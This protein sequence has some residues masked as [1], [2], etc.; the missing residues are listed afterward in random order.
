MEE[1]LKISRQ[2]FL[3]K[4]VIS[5]EESKIRKNNKFEGGLV[6]FL[7]EELKSRERLIG[8]KSCTFSK[9]KYTPLDL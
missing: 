9:V 8:A 3:E 4:E 2:L 1:L 7:D 5:T 6:S